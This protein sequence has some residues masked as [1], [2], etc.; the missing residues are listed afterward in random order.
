MQPL[1]ENYID[2]WLVPFSGLAGMRTNPKLAEKRV[3]L[4]NSGGVRNFRLPAADLRGFYLLAYRYK[5]EGFLSSEIN[6]IAQS[7]CENGRFSIGIRSIAGCMSPGTAGKSAIH[8]G[9]C[10]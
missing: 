4:Y 5:I 7:G 2:I 3:W 6:M 1:L 10:S 9:S 8:G